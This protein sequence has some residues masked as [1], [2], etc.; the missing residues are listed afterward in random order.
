[1]NKR[2]DILP[3]APFDGAGGRASGAWEEGLAEF[4]HL[5]VINTAD[6]TPAAW[7]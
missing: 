1:M 4:T 3:E 5:Q 7:A 2:C 6:R